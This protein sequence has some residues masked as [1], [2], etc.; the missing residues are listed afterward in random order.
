MH[1]CVLLSYTKTELCSSC[2]P[3]AEYDLFLLLTRISKTLLYKG[4]G[5]PVRS[6]CVSP[7]GQYLASGDEAG[8]VIL[9]ELS[10]GN[11]LAK[12]NLGHHGS[13]LSNTRIYNV[14]HFFDYLTRF[15][16]PLL[17]SHRN[18]S[19]SHGMEPTAEA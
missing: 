17:L 6:T 1:R 12:I 8:A 2:H 7:D 5:V 16:E 14:P 13:G 3:R 10:C 19:C 4:S 9:W 15:I 11:E 18:P